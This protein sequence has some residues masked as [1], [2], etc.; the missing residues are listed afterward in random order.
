M[1]DLKV[2]T[3]L[4]ANVT[5]TTTPVTERTVTVGS[6]KVWFVNGRY[7]ILTLP[8]GE[9]RQYKVEPGYKF[10]IE[11]NKEATVADLKKGMMVSAQ[12]IVEVPHTEITS[13]T[14]V[15]GSAPP[16]P[17]QVVA[18]AP[19]AP[20]AAPAPAPAPASRTEVAQARPTPAAAPAL[21]AAP[22][23]VVAAPAKP[24]KLP[25]TGSQLPLAA[26][27]GALILSAG[28]GLRKIGQNL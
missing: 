28:F 17:K 3:K 10:N 16:A 21:A 26:L 12:K 25:T 23:P 4:T 19:P 18:Q 6:G 9:N 13:N 27:L 24:K 22:A 8:N 5:T 7:V 2:G 1:H 11:G 20:K 15:T 14:T